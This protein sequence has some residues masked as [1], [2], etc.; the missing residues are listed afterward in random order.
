LRYVNSRAQS[1]SMLQLVCILRLLYSIERI[2]V[3]ILDMS[4]IQCS[5]CTTFAAKCS[6][7]PPDYALSIE[8][9]VKT[10]IIT[11]LAIQPSI[12]I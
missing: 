8:V 2:S 6:L 10:N 12:F 11:F 5:L 7:N 3:A 4:T 1:N 9:P